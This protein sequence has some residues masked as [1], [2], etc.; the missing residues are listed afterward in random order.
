MEIPRI[1]DRQDC[2]EKL[3]EEQLNLA[4]FETA[5]SSVNNLQSQEAISFYLKGWVGAISSKD[6][7]WGLIEKAIPILKEDSESVEQILQTHVLHEVFYG[8]STQERLIR[9]NRT[10]NIQWA[11]DIASG[12][13]KENSA[14][15]LSTNL[16]EWINTITDEDDREQI[17]LWSRQ[18]A[19]G[20]M[21]EQE[22]GGKVAGME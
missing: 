9:L 3:A 21:T 16:E 8:K 12:F 17:R 20:K 5:L 18:V 22:F 11:L 13:P 1:V 6:A 15:R 7:D 10:L 19:K 14:E 2:W 4:G